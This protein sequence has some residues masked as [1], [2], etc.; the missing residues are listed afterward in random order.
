MGYNL[1]LDDSRIPIDCCQ[2]MPNPGIYWDLKWEVC[3]NYDEFVRK[4]ESEGM[5]DLISFDHDLADE[6]YNPDM[7]DGQEIYNRHYDEFKEKTGLDCARWLVDYC[8]DNNLGLPPY[9][10][11]SMNPAGGKNILSL[12]Q[13][14]EKFT[15]EQKQ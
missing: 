6:H 2:Y 12:L 10:V 5:P 8:M 14:F 13:N 4:I 1:F 3:R 15:K 7:Y 11:H 9:Q